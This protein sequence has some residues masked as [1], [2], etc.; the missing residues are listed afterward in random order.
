ML[1]GREGHENGGGRNGRKGGDHSLL[2][3]ENA[4]K[5]MWKKFGE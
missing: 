2:G 5:Y 1:G 3:S 4:S